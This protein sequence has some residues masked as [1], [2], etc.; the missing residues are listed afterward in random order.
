MRADDS[1][2]YSEPHSSTSVYLARPGRTA[3]NVRG[4]LRGHLDP[5]LDEVGR[6]EAKA[7]ARA[8]VAFGPNLIV[9]SPLQR[10]LETA[11]CIANECGLG[12]EVDEALIDRDYGRWAGRALEEV[13]NEWGSVE[14][15]PGVE[16]RDEV[17]ARA[18]EAIES[19][20]GRVENSS[21]VVVAHE[22]INRLLLAL[23]D[24]NQFGLA[25]AIPQ[26]TGCFNLLH[27]S[28][29]GWSVAREDIYPGET[30]DWTRGGVMIGDLSSDESVIRHSTSRG[31][32][33]R[34]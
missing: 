29:D 15:A 9:S 26:H 13:Q 17:Q 11:R 10:A 16:P 20:A 31:A 6:F 8:L 25:E 21:A 3:L 18:C 27:R 14:K 2:G 24:P 28:T 5:R 30:I 19:I 34:R 1:D 23:L 7:L 22:A 12:V 33:D 4:A 32:G